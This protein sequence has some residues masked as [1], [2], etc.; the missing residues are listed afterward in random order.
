MSFAVVNH[1]HVEDADS[2]NASTR[3]V[4]L[5]RLRQLPGFEHAVFLADGEQGFSVIVFASRAQADD[6]AARLG[7]GAV[8]PPPGIAFERQEVFEVVAMS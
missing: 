3:D 5:P 2:A 7:S 6:M 8:P 4:V 1:V